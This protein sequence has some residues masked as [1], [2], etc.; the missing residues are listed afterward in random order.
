MSN[1]M[2]E[3]LDFDENSFSLFMKRKDMDFSYMYN[4]SQG[5]RIN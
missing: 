3:L 5:F 4:N 1:I 2:L